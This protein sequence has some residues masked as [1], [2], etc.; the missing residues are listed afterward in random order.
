MNRTAQIR[1]FLGEHI[2][3]SIADEDDIFARGLVSSMF[4]VQL[5]AFLEDNFD[6]Q[7]DGEDLVFESFRS[8]KDIDALVQRL[9]GP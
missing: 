5:V 6:I 9:T 7:I 1:Q 2:A 8:V 3:E 4:V